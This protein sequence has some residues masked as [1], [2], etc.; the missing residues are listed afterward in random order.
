M[1][2][3]ILVCLLVFVLEFSN[4]YAQEVSMVDQMVSKGSVR[5]DRQDVD[6]FIDQENKRMREIKLLN[7]DLQRADLRSRI[8]KLD[9]EDNFTSMLNEKKEQDT[10]NFPIKLQ[11]IVRIGNERLGLL[12]DHSV[13]VSAKAGQMLRGDVTVVRIDDDKAVLRTK[14]G[15]EKVILIGG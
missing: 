14:D 5:S 8:K 11:G 13:R 12:L 1:G 10:E 3:S 15:K 2:L 9:Q 4:V 7:L 6:D